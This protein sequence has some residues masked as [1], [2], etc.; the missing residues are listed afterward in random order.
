MYKPDVA[1]DNLDHAEMFPEDYNWGPSQSDSRPTQGGGT[2][3]WSTV[4]DTWVFKDPPDW[5]VDCRPGD[6]VPEEWGLL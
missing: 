3:V 2:A 4:D 5:W 6:L 1:I